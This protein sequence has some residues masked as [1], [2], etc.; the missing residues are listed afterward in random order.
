MNSPAE[1]LANIEK[2]TAKPS[3]FDEVSGAVS[4]GGIS[5]N[6]G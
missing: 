2:R 1:E 4:L 5:E 6:G 3:F